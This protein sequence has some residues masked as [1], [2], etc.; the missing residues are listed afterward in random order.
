MI[1]PKDFMNSFVKKTKTNT[2]NVKDQSNNTL[3]LTAEFV[4]EQIKSY[5][6]VINSKVFNDVA[7]Q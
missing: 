7:E 5:D 2:F 1:S 6:K 4:K 3:K